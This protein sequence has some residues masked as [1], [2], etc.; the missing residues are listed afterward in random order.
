[1]IMII[2]IILSTR[3]IIDFII[4]EKE[5]LSPLINKSEW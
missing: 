1:M 3:K 2:I 4:C 5:R